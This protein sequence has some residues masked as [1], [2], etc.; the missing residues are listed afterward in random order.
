MRVR[1]ARGRFASRGVSVRR[2]RRFEYFG[3]ALV[4]ASLSSGCGR[5]H[6]P[7]PTLDLTWSLRP[8]PPIVGPASLTV[9]LRDPHGVPL[10]GARVRLEGHMSHV[11]MAP[12]F[13]DALERAPG[14]Y[15]LSF[16]LTM[17]GDWVLLVS[18]TLAD[19]AR[20]EKRIDVANVRPP[21]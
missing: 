17:R 20:V 11:G 21:G 9:T 18:A 13:A 16:A 10:H 14:V 6:P 19:G 7:G 12:V 1:D 2:R 5:R 3:L 4:A 8:Q 15:E